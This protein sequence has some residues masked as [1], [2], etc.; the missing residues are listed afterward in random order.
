M[1]NSEENG[2]DFEQENE[3]IELLLKLQ[4]IRKRNIK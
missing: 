2:S 4:K 3:G 1:N